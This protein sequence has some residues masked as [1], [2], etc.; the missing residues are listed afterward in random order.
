MV[1]PF[2]CCFVHD[3][4]SMGV[5]CSGA[6]VSLSAVMKDPSKLLEALPV[7]M[8]FHLQF[9]LVTS[10]YLQP[11]VPPPPYCCYFSLFHLVCFCL[12]VFFCLQAVR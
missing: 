8:N 6:G 2:V 9:D 12:C 7:L 4:L 11:T 10:V 1:S 3:E 5:C